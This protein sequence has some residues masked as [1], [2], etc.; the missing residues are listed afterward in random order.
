MYLR[1]NPVPKLQMPRD[2]VSMK[3]RKKDV[4]DSETQPGGV[5]NV[6][7][8]ITLRVYYN[9]DASLCIADEVRGMGQ[10]AQVILFKNHRFALYSLWPQ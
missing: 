5:L 1:A 4:L 10:A 8:N 2:E 3:M 9:R 6:P 7:F